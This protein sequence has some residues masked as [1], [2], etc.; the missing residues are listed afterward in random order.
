MARLN[1]ARVLAGAT[2]LANQ[3][4]LNDLTLGALAKHCGV[5]P[6]SLYNHIDNLA[7]LKRDLA[8]EGFRQL[9]ARFQEA[10]VGK[11]G[12]DA[13]RA[14]AHSYRDFAR[15]NPGLFNA[16]LGNVETEDEELKEAGNKVLS[17]F[18]TLFTGLESPDN[19]HAIRAFR[20]SLTGF[21]LLELNDGFA[22]D[23]DID[24]SF[25]RMLELHLTKL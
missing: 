16:T 13:L 11:A 3:H 9:G 15:E 2:Q 8:L 12:A 22:M 7:A 23:V 17:I 25:E 4:G 19:I 24:E 21:V 10:A 1:K 6:P 20:A 18:L 5:K 14:V